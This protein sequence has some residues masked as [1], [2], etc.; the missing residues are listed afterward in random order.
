VAFQIRAAIK[1]GH[2]KFVVSLLVYENVG[3]GKT[4]VSR[5][6]YQPFLLVTCEIMPA[7]KEHGTHGPVVVVNRISEP[8]GF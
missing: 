2:K 7:C 8:T 1:V 3:S 4:S 6:I 5:Q